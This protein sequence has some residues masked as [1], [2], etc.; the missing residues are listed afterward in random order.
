MQKLMLPN[1]ALAALLA[2]PGFA[3]E[4]HT[5]TDPDNRLGWSIGDGIDPIS[6]QK[7]QQIF[8]A[9]SLLSTGNESI[10]VESDFKQIDS[11]ST[12]IDELNVDVRASVSFIGGR[13][14]NNFEFREWSQR[15]S[16]GSVLYF[17]YKVD[18]GWQEAGGFAWAPGVESY[19]A[20]PL[21]AFTQ[22]FGGEFVSAAR[23]ESGYRVTLYLSELA[24]ERTVR[25]YNK[26]VGRYA[27]AK[28]G[29]SYESLRSEREIAREVM[30]SVRAYGHSAEMVGTELPRTLDEFSYEDLREHLAGL[31]KGF[32]REDARAVEYRTTPVTQLPGLE[33]GGVLPSVEDIETNLAKDV[34]DLYYTLLGRVEGFNSLLGRKGVYGEYID[35]RS[36]EEVEEFK[37]ARREL[38]V[39]RRAVESA[40]KEFIGYRESVFA[41]EISR[42]ESAGSPVEA[43]ADHEVDPFDR[44]SEV[45]LDAREAVED[46]QLPHVPSLRLRIKAQRYCWHGVGM[47][48]KIA[49]TVIADGETVA[50]G[51]SA[52]GKSD[53]KSIR[54]SLVPYRAGAE[55]E[56]D[57]R[58]IAGD[59]ATRDPIRFVPQDLQDKLQTIHDWE[60]VGGDPQTWRT[61]NSNSPGIG[62]ILVEAAWH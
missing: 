13:A 56:I 55:Y 16:R 22:K 28:V 11:I 49:V 4:G 52:G 37:S 34:V 41:D 14:S 18:W 35:T 29:A 25:A 31:A 26:A 42:T 51:E 39:Q 10:G 62:R 36:E 9:T 54:F 27:R 43:G 17:D 59:A 58:L 44:L 32:K 61:S 57:V 46:S 21:A 53:E 1:L 33:I 60:R 40:I 5:F 50:E 3:Q 15:I 6:T 7:K 23:L 19:A 2:A 12:L 45:S 30:V 48:Y 20:K 38:R 24:S 47:D 8:T